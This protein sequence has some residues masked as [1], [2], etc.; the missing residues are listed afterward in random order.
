MNDH[1]DSF[2]QNYDEKFEKHYGFLD[3]LLFYPK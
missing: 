2:E 1:F 3:L